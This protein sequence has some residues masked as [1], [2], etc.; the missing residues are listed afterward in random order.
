MELYHV[1]DLL[2]V[3]LAEATDDQLEQASD[4]IQSELYMRVCNRDIEMAQ[5][6]AE[7]GL[8]ELIAAAKGIIHGRYDDRLWSRR[9]QTNDRAIVESAYPATTMTPR[10]FQQLLD[11]LVAVKGFFNT[12]KPFYLDN[13]E[14]ESLRKKLLGKYRYGPNL[15]DVCLIHCENTIDFN[16]QDKE[17]RMIGDDGNE[18]VLVF[19]DDFADEEADIIA[20]QAFEDDQLASVSGIDAF[21]EELGSLGV[22]VHFLDEETE[23]DLLAMEAA[24]REG[25][26]QPYEEF[27]EELLAEE[28]E[29][30]V[31]PWEDIKQHWEDKDNVRLCAVDVQQDEQDNGQ[32]LP[33]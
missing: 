10:E 11:N 12:D 20:M 19:E 16:H 14:A 32:N 15:I 27:R 22:E 24:K 18:E 23:D 21:Y 4:K 30:E 1:E 25:D 5:K 26:G 2:T 17:F 13:E 7:L 33:G 31:I 8:P 9:K 28:A 3:N 29:P 6:A